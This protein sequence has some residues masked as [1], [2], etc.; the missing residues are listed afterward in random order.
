MKFTVTP[1]ISLVSPEI[2]HLLSE[3][4]LVYSR[5]GQNWSKPD[6]NGQFKFYPPSYSWVLIHNQT[7]LPKEKLLHVPPAKAKV[8]AQSYKRFH[9]QHIWAWNLKLLTN[10]KILRIQRLFLLSRA[11]I[12]LI[13][14]KM[15]LLVGNE[16]FIGRISCS[17]ELSMKS[18]KTS[19]PAY[20]PVFFFFYRV[21]VIWV[22]TF[23]FPTELL[24]CCWMR[25]IFK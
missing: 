8:R 12:M 1:V 22:Q 14:I 4:I 17:A 21:V 9:A 6:N 18:L 13:N 2:K 15:L 19:K 24:S 11:V 16:T 23:S 7:M 3:L 10:V 5:C 20:I 25:S